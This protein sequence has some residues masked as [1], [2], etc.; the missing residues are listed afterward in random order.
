MILFSSRFFHDIGEL[1]A[2]AEAAATE[3]S[4][5]VFFLYVEQA[6]KDFLET[7]IKSILQ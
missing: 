3:D 2:V 7:Q 4:T 5:N 6:F 1:H